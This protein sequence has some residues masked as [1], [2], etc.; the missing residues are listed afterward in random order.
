[1]PETKAQ[2]MTFTCRIITPERV[3]YDDTLSALA[4]DG[5]RGAFEILPRHE[6]VMVP[7]A[8]GILRATTSEGKDA[9]FAIHGGFLNMD[10]QHVEVLADS[11][12]RGDEIDLDRAQQALNRAKERLAAVSGSADDFK[13]DL[14]RAKLALLRAISR[15][16]AAGQPV[17]E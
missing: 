12:E 5:V 13:P 1:M 3:V 10:G 14:D 6:P 2:S 9:S 7:L 17:Q 4:A 16:K 11:A 8:I 15:M